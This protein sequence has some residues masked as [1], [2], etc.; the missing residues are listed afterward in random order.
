MKIAIAGAGPAG[1]LFALLAR[2]RNP[3]WDIR[4]V[5]QN[6]ADATFGFGVVFSQGALAFLQR[7][8]P[9]L[10]AQLAERMQAWP[11]Q[12]IVHRHEQV[13][14]DGNGFSAIGRQSL[15]RFLQDLCRDAGVRLEFGRSIG[16]LDDLAEADLVVGAD[17]AN[18]FVRRSLESRFEPR[19]EWLENR[20]A[21]YGTAQSFECLTLT[22]RE[23]E[24]GAF[25][26]HHYR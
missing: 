2:R 5:E 21:W 12:R 3:G 6:P 1:L 14:I 10:Y 26:A 8:A 9:Q 25:V 23:N 17:G 15:N 20:F 7:D 18:S 22:F 11:M 13:D 4:V 19:I 16:S 24:H